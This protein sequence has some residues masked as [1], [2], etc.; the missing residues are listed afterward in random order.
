[1][2]SLLLSIVL[3][4]S[5]AAGAAQ[6]YT[7][8][9][10]QAEKTGQPLV[11]LVGADWC[12]ACQSM[13][14]SVIPALQRQGALNQVSFACVNTDR[15]Q[16]LAGQLMSGGSIPQLVMFRKTAAGWQ[17]QQLTGAQSVG[18]AASFLGRGIAT[19]S[20]PMQQLSQSR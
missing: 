12:P 10:Y 7:E 5:S 18:S 6:T 14:Q 13:K 8:A 1:M 3:Q 11:I 16:K 4:I 20:S 15:E 2:S 19:A 17:R 9:Y